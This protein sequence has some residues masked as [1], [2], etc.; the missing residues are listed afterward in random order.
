M[1][2]VSQNFYRPSEPD[3]MVGD[4][5]KAREKLNWK[6]SVNFEALVRMM[7]QSDLKRAREEQAWY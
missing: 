2:G 3:P 4:A 1:I 7:A 6:P 5:S